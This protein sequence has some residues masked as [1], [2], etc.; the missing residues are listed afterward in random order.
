MNAIPWYRSPVYV[1]AVVTIISTLL[2][3]VPKLAAA[4]GLTSPDAISHAVDSAFQLVAL[5]A[6]VFT[7]YKRQSSPDQPLT[8]TKTG[9]ETH[10]AN[11]PQPTAPPSEKAP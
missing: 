11:T 1:G 9:A 3:L 6:G 10:P 2:S 8:L 4:L 5:A 7:A